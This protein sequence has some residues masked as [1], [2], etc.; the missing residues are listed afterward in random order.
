[1]KKKQLIDVNKLF[2]GLPR[3]F[4]EGVLIMRFFSP[5]RNDPKRTHKQNFATRPVPGQSRK[6][7]YVLLFP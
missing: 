2:T 1:M 6:F 3:V 5:I 7:V 4:V